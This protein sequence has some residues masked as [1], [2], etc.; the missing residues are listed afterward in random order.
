M[1][2]SF[3]EDAGLL[4]TLASFREK[5]NF[6]AVQFCKL[7]RDKKPES[8]TSILDVSAWICLLFND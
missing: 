3:L 4:T 5:T 1:G 7:A 2:L 6:S 8:R